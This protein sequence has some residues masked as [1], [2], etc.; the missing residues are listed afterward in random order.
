[1]IDREWITPANNYNNVLESMSTFF[2]I[3]T[4]EM[5]PDMMFLAADSVGEDIVPIEKNREWVAIIYVIFIFLTS[6]FILNLF[7]SVIVDKFNEQIKKR[8]GSDMFTPEQKEWVKI[9]RLLLHTNP[10]IIPVE[11]VN[12][13]RHQ[14]FMVVQ[15]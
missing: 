6:F 1:M 15:S 8:E 9:N 13:F 12:R 11:P 7:I 3:A 4:L 5:W 2:E 10:R 14:C